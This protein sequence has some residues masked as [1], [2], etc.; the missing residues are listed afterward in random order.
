MHHEDEVPADGGHTAA[1]YA[2][3]DGRSVGAGDE[4]PGDR[5]ENVGE[6][7]AGN[8]GVEAEDHHAGE[9]AQPSH[10]HPGGIGGQGLEGPDGVALGPAPDDELGQH[11]WRADERYRQEI[12]H[13]E[14]GPAVGPRHRGEAPYV[15]EPDG[16]ARGR[17]DEGGLRA[18]GVAGGRGARVSAGVH[19]VS[20]GVG[21]VD[22]AI[23]RWWVGKVAKVRGE[24]PLPQGDEPAGRWRSP[25]VR[26][27][28]R[29]EPPRPAGPR[30]RDPE[31]R[32]CPPSSR[33]SRAPTSGP[34]S[35]G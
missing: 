18:P 1:G 2:I 25:A 34:H 26:P 35:R 31:V 30:R 27:G 28:R 16:A 19:A 15:A 12:D 23:E 24:P 33:R 3:E 29:R 17:E 7:P 9:D 21:G 4:G 5:L 10:D 8:D 22:D 32:A 13:Q 11:D 6:G 20:C 14:R